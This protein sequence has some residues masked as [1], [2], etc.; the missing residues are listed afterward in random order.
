[1]GEGYGRALGRFIWEDGASLPAIDDLLQLI[2]TQPHHPLTAARA[3]L[4]QALHQH[5]LASGRVRVEHPWK[6]GSILAHAFRHNV[7]MTVHPGIGYDIITN[8]PLFNGG[9]VGR[10]AQWDF[11][12]LGGSVDRLDGG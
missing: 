5:G 12:W 4:L 7:P 2:R 9:V 6:H 10:A 3:D 1:M 8:H 11:Q